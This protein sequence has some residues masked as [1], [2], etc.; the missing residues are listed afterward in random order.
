MAF[1]L[2]APRHQVTIS[3][4]PTELSCN[5]LVRANTKDSRYTLKASMTVA[6]DPFDLQEGIILNSNA[7]A[8]HIDNFLMRHNLQSAFITLAL[9]GPGIEESFVTT[10]SHLPP[11][12]DA[13]TKLATSWHSLY[14]YPEENGNHTWYRCGIHQRLLLQWK[15][16]FLRKRYN[17]IA[18]TSTTMAL[19]HAYHHAH[20]STHGYGRFAKDIEQHGT[21]F[22]NAFNKEFITRFVSTTTQQAAHEYPSV[23]MLC[24]LG[25]YMQGEKQQ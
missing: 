5:V 2:F 13:S 21:N 18:I 11:P 9:S 15:L 22:A 14:L 17:L 6:L 10:A 1:S 3:C 7:L 8:Q 19:F 25:L 24:A 12:A 16:L 23:H 20:G 4:T